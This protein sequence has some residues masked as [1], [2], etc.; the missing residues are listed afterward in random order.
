LQ[1]SRPNRRC[2]SS[3]SVKSFMEYSS[4]PL[5]LSVVDPVEVLGLVEVGAA[6]VLPIEVALLGVLGWRVDEGPGTVAA[7][8]GDVDGAGYGMLG[9]RGLNVKF[10]WDVVRGPDTSAGTGGTCPAGNAGAGR[11]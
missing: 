6:E 8:G 1:A 4:L 2:S 10:D 3:M 7:G 5:D 9:S 11:K